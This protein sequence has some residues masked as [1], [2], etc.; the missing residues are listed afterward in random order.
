[1]RVPKQTSPVIRLASA[2]S[3]GPKVAISG[4]CPWY[5]KIACGAAV[6]ACA[7]S[8][9]AGPEA[10]IAC[11]A[12]RSESTRL[13]SSHTEIYTLSLHDALPISGDCPWY[14]KIAC[15]AAVVACAASCLAGPEA[16]IACFAG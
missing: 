11:F 13:N 5:K 10:C 9:L 15:G 2:A 8:C 7:A 12:G 1:M 6:V 14:K 4:D 3:F 16:C